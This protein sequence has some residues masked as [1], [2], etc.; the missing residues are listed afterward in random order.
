ML[1]LTA[2]DILFY[3]LSINL[4]NKH[5]EHFQV[6]HNMLEDLL[7]QFGKFLLNLLLILPIIHLVCT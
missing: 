1:T 7:K 5:F 4:E 3:P 2:S 6:I